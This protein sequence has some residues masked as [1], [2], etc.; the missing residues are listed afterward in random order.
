MPAPPHQDNYLWAINNNNGITFWIAL[1]KSGKN[2]GGL[3][4]LKS[5]H[6]LGLLKHENSY[7][8]GTSQKIPKSLLKKKLFKKI[9]TKIK[10]WRYVDSPLSNN[11]WKNVNKVF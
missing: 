5:S 8:P 3:Y 7:M 11:S 4:Y 1:D 9:Y 6:K 10:E 2:N